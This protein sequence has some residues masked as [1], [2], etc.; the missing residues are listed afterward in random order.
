MDAEIE[1]N[2]GDAPVF[3]TAP[4]YHL[5]GHLEWLAGGRYTTQPLDRRRGKQFLVWERDRELVG[6]DALYVHKRH[7]QKEDDL[8][9]R[10]CDE[11]VELE[12]VYVDVGSPV[13]RFVLYWCRGFKGLP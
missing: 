8:L 12:P 7:R 2:A 4:N 3:L 11:V 5:A 6:W 9:R 1:A 10:S 13:R